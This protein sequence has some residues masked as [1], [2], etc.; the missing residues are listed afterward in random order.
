MPRRRTDHEI[1]TR[2]RELLTQH[3]DLEHQ[4]GSISE[5]LSHEIDELTGDAQS[6]ADEASHSV[7]LD[8]VL[9]LLGRLAVAPTESDAVEVVIGAARELLPDTSGAL[10]RQFETGAA[11]ATV[12]VW[13]QNE[14]W[15]PSYREANRARGLQGIAERGDDGPNGAAEV[16]P[17][18]GFGLTIGELRIWPDANKRT[19]DHEERQGRSEFIARSA[20]LVLA[21]MHLQHALRQGSVR[22][23]L[24]DLYNRAY[25]LET[26]EHEIHR[27]GRNNSSLA[28]FV[29]DIDR[30]GPFNDA[31]GAVAGDR[32]LQSISQLLKARFRGS[33][34]GCRYSGE[35]FALLMPE[36]DAAA[37]HERA[38][39]L[40]RAIGAMTVDDGRVT[41]SGGLASHPEHAGSARA[42][43]QASEDAIIQARHMGGDRILMASAG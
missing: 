20:G 27:S 36:A 2:L 33:D 9:E 22:D 11:M 35:R 15:H 23:P 1:A 28:L 41:I 21:G 19:L 26:L 10:C 16:F 43:I 4:L 5:Q 34:V 18:R 6:E 7:D 32:V 12:G 17:I 39:E 13:D 30:F 25:L 3:S 37:T 42:L 14:Q 38:E 31:H 8:R 24:T 29:F 40:R